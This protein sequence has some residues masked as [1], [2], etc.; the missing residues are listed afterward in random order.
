MEEEETWKA[1]EKG[2]RPQSSSLISDQSQEENEKAKEATMVEL[3]M[4]AMKEQGDEM[5]KKGCRRKMDINR[6]SSEKLVMKKEKLTE[7]EKKSIQW[8]QKNYTERI[9]I[10][11]NINGPIP[12]QRPTSLDCGIFVMY[13][14][15]KISKEQMFDRTLK[16][17]DVLKFRA[18]V[19]KRFLDHRHSWYSIHHRQ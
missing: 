4:A 14:M 15:D 17:E 8:V 1:A 9:P 2:E 19:V 16:K 6:S 18:Q 5:L 11:C 12:Q 10:S 7:R 3:W 13:Y